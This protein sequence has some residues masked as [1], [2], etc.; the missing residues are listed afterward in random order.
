[1]I[2]RFGSARF[3]ENGN[4][5]NG[6][7]GDQTGKEVSEQLYYMD[8]RGW[9]V[10]RAK[11]VDI[12]NGLAAAMK[13]ACSNDHIGYNQ[14]ERAQIIKAGIYTKTDV[15]SD[16]S[17]LVRACCIA[18]GFDPGNF[19][20]ATEVDVLAK[21]GKFMD[22][23][24]LKSKSELYKGDILVTCTKGHTVIVTEGEER[25][26][27]EYFDKCTLDTVSIID[28]LKAI[29]AS[30]TFQYRKKI[31]AVNGITNYTGTAA[32]NHYMVTLIKKGVLVK[33]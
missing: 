32:Q 31:A 3:D 19:Y 29:G 10:I 28:C 6:K 30:S 1:M 17:S 11:E 25:K 12:A 21:T 14:Y 16:C 2:V 5:K 8:K 20:T 23:F 18:C 9:Y 33:P 4:V 22:A 24:K 7:E 13:V 15:N 27:K 26:D